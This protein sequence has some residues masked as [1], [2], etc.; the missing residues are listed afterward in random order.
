MY[1]ERRSDN[2]VEIWEPE[3]KI[4]Y[5]KKYYTYQLLLVIDQAM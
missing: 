4:F 3:M 5:A 1:L 2:I